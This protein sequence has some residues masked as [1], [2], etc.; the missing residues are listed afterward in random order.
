M[1]DLELSLRQFL[2]AWEILGKRGPRYERATFP[3]VEVAFSG[4]PIAFFNASFTTGRATD[5]DTFT[6]A[7]RRTRDFAAERDV[8]WL[9]IVTHETLAPGVDPTAL[10]DGL[11]LAPLMN[12]TGMRAEKVA[13]ITRR[14]DDLEL[15]EP[16]D[17]AS[18][19]T[20]IDVNGAAYD[21]DLSES[22][23]ALGRRAFWRDHAAVIGRVDGK[24]VC[25]TA[26]FFLDGIRYVGFV[27]T[28]PAH[29]RKGYADAVMRRALE[30]AR[31]RIGE[32]TT[33]LHATDAGRPVYERM[34]YRPIST[35]TAYIE[36]KY[37]EQAH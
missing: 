4:L 16:P 34:G 5:A 19:A 12:F 21:V 36:K 28:D 15:V 13:A 33:V 20:I 27:A 14:P 25:S 29:Q 2:G 37:L 3:T 1:N 32:T 10:L 18:C 31:D 35:H 30:L 26:V 8:P 22:K 9:H 23:D 17:D 24:T 7:A 11:G 6:D